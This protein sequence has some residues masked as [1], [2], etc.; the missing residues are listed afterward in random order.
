MI[1]LFQ[2]TDPKA[3]GGL[4]PLKIHQILKL[5]LETQEPAPASSL[6][7]KKQAAAAPPKM[8]VTSHSEIHVAQTQLS[9][10]PIVGGL[11]ESGLRSAVG[12]LTLVGGGVL[13]YTG[14]LD[15]VPWAVHTIGAVASGASRL[16]SDTTAT[17][18]RMTGVPYLYHRALDVGGW[19]TTQ[20][21]RTV[22]RVA[23]VS[24]DVTATLIEEGAGVRVKCYS[25]S[26][27]AGQVC[28]SPTCPRGRIVRMELSVEN[29]Q[30]VVKGMYL[31]G[32]KMTGLIKQ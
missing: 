25:M 11:Y 14:V 5:Q 32:G 22:G 16:V 10:L 13:E 19:F 26:C 21:S 3:L 1:D 18:V 12:R 9:Q 29:L 20:A 24:R 23:E 4:V 8:V 15:A 2:Y 6:Y 27:R 17:A 7:S 30:N 31:E 28:Y